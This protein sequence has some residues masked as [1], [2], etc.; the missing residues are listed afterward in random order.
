[1]PFDRYPGLTGSI[2]DGQRFIFRRKY[3]EQTA[4]SGPSLKSFA[5]PL[6][7]C[8]ECPESSRRSDAGTKA[9]VGRNADSEACPG[10]VP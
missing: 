2:I 1:M 4:M 10:A 6:I 9:L 3:T 8:L 7:C 5:V